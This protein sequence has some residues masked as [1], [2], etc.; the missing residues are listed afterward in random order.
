MNIHHTQDHTFAMAFHAL[1]TM[2][3]FR[4]TPR[5]HRANA[6]WLLLW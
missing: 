4:A 2:L 1:E 3:L 5:T 6:H